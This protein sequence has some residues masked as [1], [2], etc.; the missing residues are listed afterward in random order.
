MG[1]QDPKSLEFQYTAGLP[2]RLRVT[3]SDGTVHELRVGLVVFNVAETG[4][5]NEDGAPQFEVRAAVQFDRV[6]K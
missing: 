2:G 4:E 6:S 5:R 3:T 1:D